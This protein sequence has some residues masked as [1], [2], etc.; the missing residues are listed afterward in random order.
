[1]DM[2]RYTERVRGFLQAAQTAAARFD[3]LE[4][5]LD[6]DGDDASEGS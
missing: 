6:D 2:E 5:H 1:M 4:R 3:A